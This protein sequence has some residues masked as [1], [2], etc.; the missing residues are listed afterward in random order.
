MIVAITGIPASGK[1]TLA[2]KLSQQ[3]KFEYHSSYDLAKQAKAI[4]GKDRRRSV[5]IVDEKKLSKA[6]AKLKENHIIDGHFSHLLPVHAC[7][8]VK[9]DRKT[10]RQRMKK[11]NYP[12]KKIVENLEADIFEIIEDEIPT[13]VPTLTINAT[14]K[15]YRPALKTI[16]TWI[17]K[18][19]T[20]PEKK[21]S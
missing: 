7:I 16:T 17:K 18:N 9:C 13:T 20:T 5:D 15:T 3:L 2:K 14:K 4:T 19:R 1:T 10:L 11:R 6:V 8:L 12:E 21:E